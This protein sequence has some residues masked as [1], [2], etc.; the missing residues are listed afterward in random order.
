MK[1]L[2][3][4]W[5]DRCCLCGRTVLSWNNPDPLREG[6]QNCCCD[7]NR[8]VQLARL[9]LFRLPEE[10]RQTCLT[11]LQTLSA[12]QLKQELLPFPESS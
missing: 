1:H 3:P 4:G 11:H 7:C 12:Q 6:T 9:R 10:E 8:L 5:S 2:P